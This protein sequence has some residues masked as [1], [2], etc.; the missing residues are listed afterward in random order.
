MYNRSDFHNNCKRLLH[1]L[2]KGGYNKTDTAT[3]IN[4]AISIPR[5]RLLNKIKTSI[6]E[7]LPLAVTYKRTPP[8]LKTIIDKN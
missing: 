1:T 3:Q 6:I 8:D 2:T 4:R 7:R 5:N